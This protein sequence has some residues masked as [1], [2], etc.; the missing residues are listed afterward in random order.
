MEGTPFDL[1][2]VP[3]RERSVRARFSDVI[4][5]D[6]TALISST[7]LDDAAEDITSGNSGELRTFLK[8]VGGDIAG[9]R[10]MFAPLCLLHKM[11]PTF[12]KRGDLI[13]GAISV[14]NESFDVDSAT[15]LRA[16]LVSAV[17][18]HP[19]NITEQSASFLLSNLDLL[20]DGDISN[21]T[22]LGKAI[23]IH[24]AEKLLE[25]AEG[26]STHSGFAEAT[27]KQLSL[28]S[29]ARAASQNSDLVPRLLALRP[30]LM[31]GPEL[32][33]IHRNW[34]I[35]SLL[36]R[37]IDPETVLKAMLQANRADLA[38]DA[39]DFFGSLRILNA[40]SDLFALDTKTLSSEALSVWF[41][42]AL[43]DTPALAMFL[44]LR[45]D[46]PV[47]VFYEIAARTQPDS[48]PNDWGADPW[49][50]SIRKASGSLEGSNRQYLSAYLLARAFG[51]RSH[52]Q[53]DLIEY[54]F[55]EVYFSALNGRLSEGAW[56]LLQRAL[57]RS[58]FFDWDRCQ[59]L[60]DAVT[61]MYVN[62]DLPPEAFARITRD[63]SLFAELSRLAAYTSRGRKY[64]K[65]VLRVLRD[66]D[67][68]ESRIKAIENVI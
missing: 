18:Q 23:W 36:N 25:L 20:K 22:E 27:V 52:S 51:Y 16:L 55:D 40:I 45:S 24:N 42:F 35:K 46:P 61:D 26:D 33:S 50:T 28:E 49:I 2:F 14:I 34:D 56:G 67:D 7:W 38:H 13:D 44:N 31:N 15:S 21:E 9:G 6:R 1:Q 11:I 19:E 54:A 53:P 62:R 47:S 48:I 32:W 65:R 30:D 29:L 37:S 68:S 39:V 4:D 43:K 66:R 17:A 64:L 41:D 57:P 8:D 10:E 3:P 12:G 5:A 58:W 60:R 59:K 63:N